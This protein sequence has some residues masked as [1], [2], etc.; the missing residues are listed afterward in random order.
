MSF[1]YQSAS[2]LLSISKKFRISLDLIS[3]VRC[4]QKWIVLDLIETY[5]GLCAL[6]KLKLSTNPELFVLFYQK[7]IWIIFS[8]K[9][10]MVP[11]F[12][13]WMT[14]IVSALHK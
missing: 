7:G 12:C 6:Y 3:K 5:N 1:I 14:D 10:T 8:Y 11:N 4:W 2:N 13:Q 9:Q